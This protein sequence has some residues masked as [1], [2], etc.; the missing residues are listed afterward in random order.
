MRKILS[1]IL[2]SVLICSLSTLSEPG[3]LAQT[4]PNI[5]ILIVNGQP[6]GEIKF[7]YGNVPLRTIIDGLGGQI[8]WD[9]EAKAVEI[10]Y[11]QN[12][13]KGEIRE[14]VCG[15]DLNIIFSRYNI[16]AGEYEP[17]SLNYNNYSESC[18]IIDDQI[19]LNRDTCQNLLREFGFDIFFDMQNS[20]MR[21]D[22]YD[23]GIPDTLIV[24][25]KITEAKN[26]SFDPGVTPGKCLQL[27]AIIEAIG[28]QVY[29]ENGTIWITKDSTRIRGTRT[30]RPRKKCVRDVTSSIITFDRYNSSTGEYDPIQLFSMGYSGTYEIVNDTI[31]ISGEAMEYLLRVFGYK[32]TTDPVAHTVTLE[33]Y[34]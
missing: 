23:F 13:Y 7:H 8:F 33:C 5:T 19:Y 24:D 12:R 11:G 17:I 2:V 26:V 28:G 14:C 15:M 16:L 20:A 34:Y 25:G 18:E 21:V 22:T 3:I 6:K 32:L 27:R 1:F 4:N 31:Y 9:A 10:I 29:W 30:I